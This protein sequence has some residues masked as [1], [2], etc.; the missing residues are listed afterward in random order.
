[1]GKNQIAAP[2][3]VHIGERVQQLDMLQHVQEFSAMVVLVTGEPGSGKSSL[4]QAAIS[5]LSVHHQILAIDAVTSANKTSLIQ[6]ISQQLAC[7]ASLEA[8]D[9]AL[10]EISEQNESVHLVVD[11][12]HLLEESAFN[13]IIR[14]AI[15]DH[16]WHLVICGD[17]GLQS[18][19]DNLQQELQQENTYHLIQLAP[20]NESESDQFIEALFQQAGQD[21]TQITNKKRHQLWLL[22]NGLP[23]KLVELVEL[24]KET[25]RNLS[26]KFPVGHVA[27]IFLIG[28][29]L[30]FSYF[31]QDEVVTVAQDDVIAELLA[32][33]SQS[34]KQFSFEEIKDNAVNESTLQE[35]LVSP[36]KIEES[37]KAKEPSKPLLGQADNYQGT[38]FPESDTK[39]PLAS[40]GKPIKP[41]KLDTVPAQKKVK[42]FHPLLDAQPQEYALQLLGVRSKKS[43]KDFMHRFERQLSSEK[44]NVYETKYKGQPWF[45]VVYGPYQNKQNASQEA[46][47]LARSLKSQP[48]V[49]PIAKIQEDI[50]KLNSN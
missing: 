12:A 24:E 29:A 1:M 47:S 16:S 10:T 11:D 22:S 49:R 5:Q 42:S 28:T 44:L 34:K 46:L 26:S 7:D 19:L 32:Q 38:E 33:K 31:Y 9:T 43:A 3:F 23:G 25:H 18:R 13:L 50:R 41:A 14:K 30:I 8:I 36:T 39:T 37:S 4:L 2:S 40:L 45:V 6:Q 21:F 48:W 27:A 35:V 17:Q 15:Q 20:F